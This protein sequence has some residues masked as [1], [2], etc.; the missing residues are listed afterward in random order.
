MRMGMRRISDIMDMALGS[1]TG[2]CPAF[3]PVLCDTNVLR[4]IPHLWM[5]I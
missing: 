3:G 1:D 2:A 4:N 5:L